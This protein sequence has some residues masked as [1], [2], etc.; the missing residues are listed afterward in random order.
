MKRSRN[1]IP[2]RRVRSIPRT[3]S[4]IALLTDFGTRDHFVGTVKGVILSI[5]P[6]AT[7]VDISH[8]V[9]PQ[10]IRQAGYLLWAAYKYF[11]AGT[12]FLSVV[13]PGV[14]T[15][16]RILAVRTA[17]Y[18]FLAPDNKLLD[19]V[20]SEEKVIEAVEVKIQNSPYILSPV[21]QTFH[22]RDIFAPVAAYVANGVALK[23]IGKRI[24][25]RPSKQGLVESENNKTAEVLHIDRFGN[26]V[27]NIRVSKNSVPSTKLNSLMMNKKRVSRWVKSYTEASKQTPSLIAGSSGLVEIIVKNGSAER[28]LRA[29]VGDRMT[30]QWK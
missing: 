6:S 8:E 22:A 20:L 12:V 1:D 17:K 3:H 30:I 26:V 4:V 29:H 23:E 28:L 16:R 2:R 18:T 19:F 9:Q 25:L 10:Q 24:T 27:T 7:I 5:N 15:R 11:P 14:G 21:S 13:D